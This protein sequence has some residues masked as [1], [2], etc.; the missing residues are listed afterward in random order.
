VAFLPRSTGRGKVCS[1]SMES[2]TAK[3]EACVF[4][5]STSL[6]PLDA[7]REKS[8]DFAKCVL[9]LLVEIV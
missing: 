7:V 6:L 1:F 9:D 4:E 2:S 8:Y 3:A 5:A